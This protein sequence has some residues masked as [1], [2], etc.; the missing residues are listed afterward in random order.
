ME[1]VL[2]L[3]ASQSSEPENQR[4]EG[5]EFETSLAYIASSKLGSALKGDPVCLSVFS[6]S[7]YMFLIL[8]LCVLFSISVSHPH[9]LSFPVSVS[10]SLSQCF[11]GS[12]SLLT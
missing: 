1:L 3:K 6:F 4:Q 10:T 5:Y 11:S 7:V 12:L 2:T 9:R 8:S